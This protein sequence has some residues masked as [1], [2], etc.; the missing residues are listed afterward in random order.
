MGCDIHLWAET[1]D[2]NTGWKPVTPDR[3][4]QAVRG[5]NDSGVFEQWDGGW[6]TSR[7]YWLFSVLAGVRNDGEVEPISEPRGLP[8]D[9]S[10]AVRADS[11]EWGADG[12]SH[13]W[14]SLGEIVAHDWPEPDPGC[15]AWPDTWLG[16]VVQ[17][18]TTLLAPCRLVFWFDN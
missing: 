9:V 5:D 13:T 10:D 4:D 11:D 6:Q 18:L 2:E 1:F 16:P 15:P 7:N 17:T 3:F 12:H 14:L 8:D